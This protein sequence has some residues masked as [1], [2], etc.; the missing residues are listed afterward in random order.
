MTRSKRPGRWWCSLGLVSQHR[1]AFLTSGR[2]YKLICLPKRH[3]PGVLSCWLMPCSG[4]NGVWTLQKAGKPL[5][6]LKITFSTA[7]PSLTHQV[8]IARRDLDTL[9]A[10]SAQLILSIM[11]WKTSRLLWGSSVLARS[12]SLPVRMWTACMCV[13]A[14]QPI[15]WLSCM[16][17]A[18]LSSA[19]AATEST[20]ETLRWRR[21]SQTQH[22]SVIS[23][24]SVMTAFVCH[25]MALVWS[26]ICCRPDWGKP[27]RLPG[28][29]CCN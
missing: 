18:L 26:A 17:I 19:P 27:L 6:N 4:P 3:W 8:W 15:C 25:G 24:I 16:A 22:L 29:I 13:L 7:R 23:P 12:R 2:I 14:Y 21:Y 10:L 1:V 11:P 5:P 9:S 20:L 28:A